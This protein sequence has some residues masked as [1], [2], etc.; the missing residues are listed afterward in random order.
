MVNVIIVSGSVCT[1]KTVL[2]KAIAK[3][4]GYRYIDVNK[5]IKEQ[6]LSE[7]FDDKRECQIVD[8]NKLANKLVEII[9]ESSGGLVI[10]SHMA[11][12]I[13]P[14][15]VD[16]CIIT[17]CDLKVLKLRLRERGY[18]EAKI[19]ENLEAE[20]MDVCFNEAEDLDHEIFVIN[21][22]QGFNIKALLRKIG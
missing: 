5:V 16:K 14:E 20:I 2:A 17:K 3:E 21:T 18:D 10:D 1:G 6:G 7:G 4:L 11:H 8:E 19:K 22:T 9:K 13:P 12:F 15:H